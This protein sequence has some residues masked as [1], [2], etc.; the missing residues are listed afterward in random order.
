M[1]SKKLTEEQL[2]KLDIIIK[3]LFKSFVPNYMY[4]TCIDNIEIG[5]IDTRLGLKLKNKDIFI[6]DIFN[7]LEELEIPSIITDNYPNITNGDWKAAIHAAL[8]S[9]VLNSGTFERL[10]K[11]TEDEL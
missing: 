9:L 7:K 1:L 4:D 11:I 10:I 6:Y 2:N 5:Y 8:V 3:H